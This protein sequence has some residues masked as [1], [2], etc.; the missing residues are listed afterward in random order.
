MKKLFLFA[1][2]LG[3]A[4]VSCSKKVDPRPTS[5]LVGEWH[6]VASNGDR[7]RI[8]FQ[9][10]FA[11]AQILTT[12]GNTSSYT[13]LKG[14]YTADKQTFNIK[15]TSRI[16]QEQDKP[17]VESPYTGELFTDASYIVDGDRLS[18]S[19]SA[20]PATA[21]DKVTVT[22]QKALNFGNDTR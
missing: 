16:I 3:I 13:M 9:D 20:D 5:E 7:S 19:H 14:T 1:L 6:H 21:P 11:F 8:I 22:F 18:I 4:L 17:K 2:S 12:A 15:L 10:N